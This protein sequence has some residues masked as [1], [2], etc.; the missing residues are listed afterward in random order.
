MG[1]IVK[2]AN[3]KHKTKLIWLIVQTVKQKLLAD[4]KEEQLMMEKLVVQTV[5]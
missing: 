2:L 3:K 1:L 4:A 5:L